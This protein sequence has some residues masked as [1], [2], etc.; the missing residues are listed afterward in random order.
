MKKSHSLL[1]DPHSKINYHTFQNTNDK[2]ADQ[3]VSIHRL[4]C[5]F[6]VCI[7]Q[8]QVFWRQGPF[9]VLK[10]CTTN[11]FIPTCVSFVYHKK[12]SIL[13]LKRYLH[14]TL[15]IYKQHDVTHS[16]SR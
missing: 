14:E 4:V 3:I 2:G 11:I 12:N 10:A 9:V 1:D 5:A 7:Q 6:I 15:R 13:L 16:S 8:N